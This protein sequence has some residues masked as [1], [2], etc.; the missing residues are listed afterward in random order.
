LRFSIRSIQHLPL[1]IDLMNLEPY[2]R[3]ELR[4]TGKLSFHVWAVT[5]DIIE[6]LAAMGLFGKSEYERQLEVSARQLA[7]TDRQMEVFKAQQAETQRQIEAY[8]K[9]QELAER[10]HQEMAATYQRRDEIA[11]R[12][13]EEMAAQL[14]R[15]AKL[16][17]KWEEQA[18]RFDAVLSSMGTETMRTLPG[19]DVLRRRARAHPR[20]LQSRFCHESDTV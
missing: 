12:Q 17:D 19:L 11:A 20:L 4:E 2:C 18:Q 3:T 15:H 13:Q 7:E 6:F 9:R 1:P 10:H 14:E 16:L 8:N 5:F